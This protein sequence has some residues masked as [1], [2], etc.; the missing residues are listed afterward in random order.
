MSGFARQNLRQIPGQ[1]TSRGTIMWDTR[2][3]GIAGAQQAIQHTR[4]HLG[5]A[6]PVLVLIAADTTLS[7]YDAA[8]PCTM[9]R[10]C[11]SCTRPA[12]WANCRCLWMQIRFVLPHRYKLIWLAGCCRSVC[13]FSMPL[14]ASAVASWARCMCT[15]T[16]KCLLAVP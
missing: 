2:D 11:P 14:F 13:S 6:G 1:R 15:Y 16:Q 7:G 10:C 12:S 5:C 3:W 8:A 4:P 9:C